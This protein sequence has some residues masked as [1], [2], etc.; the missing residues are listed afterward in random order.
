MWNENL[1]RLEAP[2]HFEHK[3]DS[4]LRMLIQALILDSQ[5]R[6][7][8]RFESELPSGF[9]RLQLP[10]V[11]ERRCIDEPRVGGAP[12]RHD[13][14][15]NI[16]ACHGLESD[17]SATTEDFVV[18]MWREYDRRCIAAEILA[19]FGGTLASTRKQ[20]LGKSF[21]ERSGR[22]RGNDLFRP[23]KSLLDGS[24]RR[25]SA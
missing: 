9:D 12:I 1:L 20:H 2:K 16:R 24:H 23:L 18:R 10:H 19:V 5:K 8:R 13:H 4:L 7:R 14:D 17:R 15:L 11:D 21:P 25:L 3:L 6:V 22:G